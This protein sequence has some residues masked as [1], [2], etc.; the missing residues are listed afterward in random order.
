MGCNVAAPAFHDSLQRHTANVALVEA[1]R[2]VTY[3]ALLEIAQRFAERLGAG[4]QLVFLEALNTVDSIA[5]YLACRTD[6]HPVHLFSGRDWP[7]TAV[8]IER[9]QPNVVWRWRKGALVEDRPIS[10]SH[11]LHPDLRVLLSTSG[12]TGTP[13]FVKLSD[14]NLQAN[15]EAICQY[16]ALQASDRAVT[17]LPFNYSYGMSVLNSHLACGA[18]LALTDLSVADREFWALFRKLGATSFAGVPHTFEILD[19]A[20]P[21]WAQ[22]SGL[23]YATQAGGRLAPELVRRFARLAEKHGWLFYVM[24]GQTEAAPRIAYLPPGRAAEFAHCIGVPVPGGEIELIDD[25]GRLVRDAEM[26][27]STEN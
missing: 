21:Q 27:I 7:K 3:A 24:Y 10:R 13:K 2:T 22:I 17:T 20:D 1:G 8:L 11:A 18:S 15:A 12:S 23:R 5:A 16:L 14:R 26:L 4:R 25:S 19:R 6:G 9:Y